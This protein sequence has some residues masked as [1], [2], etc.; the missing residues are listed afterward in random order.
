[1]TISDTIMASL[2]TA[3]NEPLRSLFAPSNSF[4]SLFNA[5]SRIT[6]KTPSTLDV[7]AATT[8][9]MSE[10]CSKGH[11]SFVADYLLE[12]CADPYLSST[13]IRHM[14]VMQ[15]HTCQAWVIETAS[16]ILTELS[17]VMSGGSIIA[18]PALISKLSTKL[19]GCRTANDAIRCGG[20]PFDGV[21]AGVCLC[22]LLN[23]PS[24][25]TVYD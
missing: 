17:G 12:I 8:A 10:V 4:T 21:S 2:E 18:N 3:L 9:L 20:L 6:G 13:D 24:E 22:S 1:L 16:S 25:P 11:S 5:L 23:H 14:P 19:A 7:T 15:G